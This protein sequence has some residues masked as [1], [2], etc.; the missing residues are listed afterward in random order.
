MPRLRANEASRASQ[1][2][3]TSGSNQAQ[4]SYQLMTGS[5]R[6][7]LTGELEHRRDSLPEYMA[8]M[9]N[10]TIPYKHKMMNSDMKMSL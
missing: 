6:I 5:G 4:S 10:Q 7:P 2:A 3:R 8:Y 9:N 1:L